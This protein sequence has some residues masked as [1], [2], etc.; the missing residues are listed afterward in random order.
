[1]KEL[2]EFPALMD[3]TSLKQFF[4]LMDCT[5]FTQTSLDKIEAALN[6]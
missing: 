4:L 5:L 2:E 3:F 1:M 6:K